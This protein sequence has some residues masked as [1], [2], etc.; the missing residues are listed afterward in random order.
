MEKSGPDSLSTVTLYPKRHSS[1]L[2]NSKEPL[3]NEIMGT[4]KIEKDENSRLTVVF[5][6]KKH[7]DYVK[8]NSTA[9]I[10]IIQC[11]DELPDNYDIMYYRVPG[12]KDDIL[13]N[14][15]ADKEKAEKQRRDK[16]EA[17]SM[18]RERERE[19][20]SARVLKGADFAEKIAEE[21]KKTDKKHKKGKSIMLYAPN[22][23]AFMHSEL[24]RL[25]TLVLHR[26]IKT[27]QPYIKQAIDN[28][29][30]GID[31]II[32][33]EHGYVDVQFPLSELA[34]KS[35]Y[36][37]V[38]AEILQLKDTYLKYDYNSEDGLFRKFV[39]VFESVDVPLV[40]KSKMVT[41]RTTFGITK[42]LCNPFLPEYENASAITRGFFSYQSNVL[43][44]VRSRITQRIYLW[45]SSFKN[46]AS[47]KVSFT[48]K[49]IRAMLSLEGKYDNWYNF[50]MRI[51]EDT[52]RE[53]DENSYRFDLSFRYTPKYSG[54]ATTGFPN[55]IEFEIIDNREKE[56]YQTFKNEIEGIYS[57]F[58]NKSLSKLQ[59]DKLIL[60]IDSDTLTYAKDEIKRI[61]EVLSQG[62][63]RNEAAF[64]YKTFH[65]NMEKYVKSKKKKTV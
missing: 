21:K 54:T 47:K 25:Q 11:F 61:E 55:E 39:N 46:S 62:T 57:F 17:E 30:N 32:E 24:T 10:G 2:L 13:F 8:S 52:K 20:K 65:S 29:R 5:D 12:K 9:I 48:I 27:L 64:I 59:A 56:I 6:Q 45:L 26:V 53:L 4:V 19:I 14:W 58:E 49:H 51:L 40:G 50:K 16:E 41:V 42:M 33:P 44:Y 60:F 34:F 36:E 23:L 28:H 35:E 18:E 7:Y 63:V 1:L 38:E 31:E 3:V 15:K 22:S 37:K 43:D